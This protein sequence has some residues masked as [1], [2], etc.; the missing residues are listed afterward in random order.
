MKQ[1]NRARRR[2]TVM[3]QEIEDY[4]KKSKVSME[5]IELRNLSTIAYLIILSAL[6][7]NESR[8][9]HYMTDYPDKSDKFL[10]DTII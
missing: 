1:L 7:R 8:G 2:L 6:R 3:Y 5:L 9:L 4:Y 10:K